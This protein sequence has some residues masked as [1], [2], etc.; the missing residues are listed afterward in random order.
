MATFETGTEWFRKVKSAAKGY[1]Q[2]GVSFVGGDKLPLVRGVIKDPKA[3]EERSD[4]VHPVLENGKE[5]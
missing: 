3:V 4:Y 1:L 2:K 5:D